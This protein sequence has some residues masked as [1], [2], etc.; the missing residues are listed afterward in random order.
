MISSGTID[1]SGIASGEYLVLITDGN[2][3]VSK[4]IIKK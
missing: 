4:K 2:L 1:I 3:T